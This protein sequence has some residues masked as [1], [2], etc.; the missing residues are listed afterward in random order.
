MLCKVLRR[1]GVHHIGIENIRRN[2]LQTLRPQPAIR[3]RALTLFSHS[4]AIKTFQ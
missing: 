3:V 2:F 4:A 1:E